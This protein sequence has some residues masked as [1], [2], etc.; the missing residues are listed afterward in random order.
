MNNLLEILRDPA[1]EGI[2]ALIAIL[3]LVLPLVVK[4]RKSLSSNQKILAFVKKTA[5]ITLAV[6][7]FLPL[8]RCQGTSSDTYAY[9]QILSIFEASTFNLN[10]FLFSI[11]I[12]IAFIWPVLFIFYYSYGHRSKIK[13][14][15]KAIEPLLCLG[16]F[17][18][19][20]I[21][22]MSGKLLF[23]GYVAFLSI[24]SYFISSLLERS[25][26]V[27]Y[28]VRVSIIVIFLSFMWPT[29]HDHYM[30]AKSFFD[31]TINQLIG[32]KFKHSTVQSPVYVT[33]LTFMDADTKTIMVTETAEL[34]NKAVVDG[35]QLAK[36]ANSYLEINHPGHK[37]ANTDDN[38]NKFLNIFWDFNL[39]KGD[40]I[41]KIV[42]EMMDPHKVDALVAGQYLE[43]KGDIINVR[44][45]V[46]SKSK[47]SIVS[48][49]LI[50]QKNELICYDSHNYSVKRLCS[51]TH[52]K[53]QEAV[54]KLLYSL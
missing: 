19:L 44:P 18:V 34:I 2:A 15:L 10:I 7:F 27:I 13:S 48:R 30:F 1:W 46:V 16:T 45:F 53:I 5:S 29:I 26:G 38:V 51:E 9:K 32:Q 17:Y 49:N 20:L 21:I 28:V 39:S 52:Y 33:H 37:L 23:G 31:P 6:S 8:S 40:K 14:I 3:V 41:Q 54:Q 35:M 25:S 22:T 24:M 11:I 47:K 4:A 36:N 12:L 42:T 43:K 50:F